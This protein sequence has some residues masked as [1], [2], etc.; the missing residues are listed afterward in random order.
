M[1]ALRNLIWLLLAFLMVNA[2]SATDKMQILSINTDAYPAILGYLHLN[3]AEDS[4][5]IPSTAGMDITIDKTY[6]AAD[7]SIKSL[8]EIN[9]PVNL[10]ICVDASGSMTAIQLKNIKT[11]I[12][13]ALQTIPN[14]TFYAIA[15]FGNDFKVHCDFSNDINV[16]QQSV[17][18]ISSKPGNTYLHF[19]LDKALKY[20][21]KQNK[22]GLS[23][24]LVIS[25][26]KEQVKYDVVSQTD[27]DNIIKQALKQNVAINSIGYSSETNPDFT[28]LDYFSGK[29]YGMFIP[30]SG[31]SALSQAIT[32]VMSM[33]KSLYQL[34][35]KVSELPGDGNEHQLLVSWKTDKG[36]ISANRTITIPANHKSYYTSFFLRFYHN[37]PLFY[38]SLAGLVLLIFIIVMIIINRNKKKKLALEKQLQ[39]EKEKEEAKLKGE[40]AGAQVDKKVEGV[41]REGRRRDLTEIIASPSL[42]KQGQFSILKVEFTTGALQGKVFSLEKSGAAIGRSQDNNIVIGE[43]IVSRN[44]AKIEYQGGEF[45]IT[46]QNSANGTFINGRKITSQVIQHN[47]TFKI[48]NNEGTF[49]LA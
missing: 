4:P 15:D 27:K 10:L 29:T 49:Y 28:I 12:S 20:L 14:D 19:N 39:A 46:D 25:D 45:S 6:K 37:P 32:N 40:S 22:V 1:K 8:T 5:N 17:A 9:K 31:S 34:S 35:F 44:H 3:G 16:L 7:V 11:A 33:Q 23:S 26:G 18:E 42:H 2:L 38:G 36:E 30:L 43:S 13:D 47:D 21:S 41:I 48:G 24:I